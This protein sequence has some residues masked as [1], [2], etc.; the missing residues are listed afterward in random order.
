[1]DE[2]VLNNPQGPGPMPQGPGM[3]PQGQP[4][5]QAAPG[6]MPQ[7]PGPMQQGPG[8]MPQGPGPMGQ[9]AN[10]QMGAVA[11]PPPSQQSPRIIQTNPDAKDGQTK[12]PKCGA[13]DI[14]QNMKTSKLRCNFCRHEFE[15]ELVKDE[16]DIADLEGFALG[17]GATDIIPDVSEVLTLRCESCGAEVVIDTSEASQARCHWCRNTLSINS[18]VPNGAIP[19]MVLPFGIT[20]QDAEGQ[21]NAFVKKRRLFAHPKFLREFTTENICGV[22]FPYMVVDVNGHMSL[23]GVGEIQ[24]DKYTSGSGDDKETLYDADAYRVER[25][26]DISID[27]LT[28]ESSSDKL[29][30][31]AEDKTTN[32]INAIL[33][34]DTENCV[35]YDS[36]FLKGFTSEKRDT[37]VDQLRR[38]VHA[39][40]ADIAKFGANDTLEQYDRGV[41]WSRQNFEVK[42]ESWK[43][44]YLPV[45][46]YSYMQEK[47]D[48]SI[49]HY[50]AV[51]ARTQE[52][53]GS[54]PINYVRLS[55]VSAIV[56]VI[57]L[58]LAVIFTALMWDWED[59][60]GWVFATLG[61]I[62]FA[63]IVAFYRNKDARH[64]YE[65][66]TRRTLRNVRK[67]D[68]FIEHRVGL[69]DDSVAGAN[70]YTLS[71]EIVDL[72]PVKK[73]GLL[74]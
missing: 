24:T 54:V 20:K 65:H 16:G 68:R 64:V 50:V 42:G 27:D 71:G 36:N 53:M 12:C 8:M 44:A 72:A 58:I 21:I 22:F 70:Q 2:R 67:V 4:P 9:P 18:A 3:M 10:P 45:W 35:K 26:F 11:A 6:Q 47:G 13:T 7:G 73:K 59:N 15:L 5:M 61:F 28:I 62:F 32:V 52:T 48:K 56:E 38:T 41:A 39:R 25:E 55:I 74:K 40:S 14:S 33:P 23:S 37:N 69:S 30:V 51:N 57:G 63:L 60:Y 43:A 29:D 1:M 66:E 49:M 34:F 31:N 17:A 46:L 19:D